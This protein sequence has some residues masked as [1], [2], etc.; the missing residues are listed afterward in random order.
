MS[1][2]SLAHREPATI[3]NQPGMDYALAMSRV[4]GDAELLK[5]LGVLFLEEYPRLL[6]QLRDARQQ[7]EAV[8]LE[9]AAHAL[10]GSVANFG[11]K[12][13]VEIAAQIEQSGSRGDLAVDEMLRSLELALLSLHAELARL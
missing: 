4:G 8:Q 9:R 5:E 3:Q 2:N 6:A 10:K 7:G 13:A 11:A 1:I 12:D